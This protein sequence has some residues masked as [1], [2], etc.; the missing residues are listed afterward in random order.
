MLEQEGE[1]IRILLISWKWPYDVNSDEGS[2]DKKMKDGNS[3][4][5]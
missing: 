1:K 5:D 2:I 3:M 4:L